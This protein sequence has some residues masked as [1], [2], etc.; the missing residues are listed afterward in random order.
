MIHVVAFL[1]AQPGKRSELLAAVRGNL[2]AVLAEHGC[3]EYGPAIDSHGSPAQFGED[4]IVVL[5]KWR[6]M[7]ALMAH[8]KAPHMAAFGAATKA[9]V[10]GRKIH[11]LQPA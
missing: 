1:T 2:E 11:I 5:E 8:A 7:D 9:L 4:V 3:I 10:A 6:D